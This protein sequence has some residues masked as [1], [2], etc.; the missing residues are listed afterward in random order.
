[1]NS[2]LHQIQDRQEL[3]QAAGWSAAALAKNHGATLRTLERYFRKNMGKSPKAW[4]IEQRQ[5]RA[6]ALLREGKSVKETAAFLGYKQATTFS[7]EF[8]K[9][10]GN[11]PTEHTRPKRGSL[12][13]KCPIKL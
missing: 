8:M 6:I 12:D 5:H 4:L 1:M 9:H 3:A 7:R 2:H 13:G 10:S 11:Y